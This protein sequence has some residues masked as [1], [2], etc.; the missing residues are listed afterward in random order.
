MARTIPLTQRTAANAESTDDV[1]ITLVTIS[2]ED[3]IDGPIRLSSDPTM[4]IDTAQI[5]W[6]GHFADLDP[7]EQ[8]RGTVS[9]GET[10]A[11]L[12]MSIRHPDDQENEAARGSLT[13]ENIGTGMGEVLR[14]VQTQAGVTLALVM[15]S[16]PDDMDEFYTGLTIQ[17]ATY[18]ADSVTIEFGRQSYVAEPWPSARMT[19]GRFPGLHR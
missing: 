19:K 4:A 2:H 13:I 18:A 14:S 9:N 15:S 5:P 17:S 10:Y 12:F 1:P 6:A 16:A 11:F 8:P 7:D 3:I